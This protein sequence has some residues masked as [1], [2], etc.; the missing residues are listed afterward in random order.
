MLGAQRVGDRQLTEISV[1]WRSRKNSKESAKASGQFQKLCLTVGRGNPHGKTVLGGCTVPVSG[2]SWPAMYPLGLSRWRP[3][4]SGCILFWQAEI[5]AK[6]G[7]LGIG[8]M[9]TGIYAKHSSKKAERSRAR[10]VSA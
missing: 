5:R 1:L 6:T 8:E 9:V 10:A 4:Q 2:T 3:M 7:E